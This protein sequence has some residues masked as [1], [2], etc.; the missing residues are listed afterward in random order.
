MAKY[1]IPD[2]LSF[3]VQDVKG[4]TALP[5]GGNVM[6]LYPYRCEACGNTI[7]VVKLISEASNVV[8]CPKCG[9]QMVRVFT[10]FGFSFG[11]RLTER[12]HNG[13]GPKEEIERAI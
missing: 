8:E 11:W 1:P 3:V 6:P 9:R 10:S 4:T 2:Y 12:A 5:N 13:T 7:D